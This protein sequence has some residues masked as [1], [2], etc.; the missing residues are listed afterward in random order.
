MILFILE[1]EISI[2]WSIDGIKSDQSFVY[3]DA[4]LIPAI[5]KNFEIIKM[6]DAKIIKA[7]VPR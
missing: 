5:L 1:G 6:T 7:S 2:S 3:G 4:I